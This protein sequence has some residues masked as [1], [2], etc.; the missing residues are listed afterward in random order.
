MR[1]KVTSGMVALALLAAACASGPSRRTA[2]MSGFRAGSVGAGADPTVRPARLFPETV[3]ERTSYG[4]EAGGGTRLIVS[5]LRIVS[6]SKGAIVAAE[7]RLPGPPQITMPLPERLGGGFLFV[8]GTTLWRTDRWLGPAKPIFTSPQAVHAV[9]PGLDRVYLLHGP[10]AVIALDGRSGQVLDLGPWPSSP[11]VADYAAADGWRAAA[12]A[13]MRGVVATFDA[14]AT[15]RTLSLPMQASQVVAS[16]DS[17][18][19]GGLDAARAD[20]WYELRADGSV[21]RLGS[22]PREAKATI[23]GALVPKGAPPPPVRPKVVTP[24]PPPPAPTEDKD[25]LAAKTFGKRPLA[26]AIEDGWPLTDGTAVVARDGSLARIRLVDGALTEL[27]RD[28]FPLKSARCHP[29]SLARKSNAG[30][31][32]FVCGEPRGATVL[33]AYEPVRGQL[34]ELKRFDKPRVVVS[35]GNGALTVRGPCAEDGDPPPPPRPDVLKLEKEKPGE[36]AKDEPLSKSVE[37][38]ARAP[39]P[40]LHPYCVYGHDDAWREIHVR[41]DIGGERVVVLSDGRI[42]VISPPQGAGAPARLTILDANRRATTVPITFPRVTSDVGRVLRLGLWLD[43]FEER[44]AGVLGGWIEAGGT[45]LGIEL[46]LDGKATL[47]AFLRDAGMPFVSGRY[48]LG[49]TASRL[50]YETTDGGMTWTNIEVPEPLVPAAKVDRRACGPVGCLAQGWLRVGWGEAKNATPQAAPP[51]YRVASSSSSTQLQLA[52][53]PLATMPPHATVARPTPTTPTTIAGGRIQLG[54]TSFASPPV[55]GGFNGLSELPPFFSHAAPALRDSER[56]INVDV[57][58]LLGELREDGRFERLSSGGSIARVYGWGPRT[59]DWDTLGRW[60]VK[61]QSPFFGWPDIRSSLQARPPPLV[62]DATRPAA[63]GSQA[64]LASSNFQLVPGDDASHALLVARRPSRS[65]VLLYELDSDR[66]PVEIRRAD[67]EPWNEIEGS[68]RAAGLWFVATPSPASSST[69]ATL[70]WQV[71]GGVARELVRVPRTLNTATPSRRGRLAR[72]SD[73]R[74]IALVSDGRQTL[75]RAAATRWALPIDLETGA[76]GEPESLGYVDLAERTVD[77]CS[78][79]LVGWV[80]DTTTQGVSIRLR[81]PH[82]GGALSSPL[83]R[84]RQTSSRVCI[85][86]LAGSFDGAHDG[87]SPLATG[88]ASAS[89]TR[90]TA[91]SRPG[92]L[93]VAASSNGTRF[94][95]R[96]SVIGPTA[97]R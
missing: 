93:Y 68:V 80:F 30:A 52:C 44:R 7:D 75:E 48:G 46:A 76:L 15:W 88:P 18:A 97:G 27:V 90:G 89:R 29:V 35:S 86:R 40:E 65:D 19:I 5:G 13:D 53:E 74:A 95:L 55:L 42:A 69:L 16:G 31:F 8:I 39:A 66:A 34:V 84:I 70:I 60:Q 43:G 67:G 64:S 59:G 28:A 78:D 92:E 33:Y 45:M 6:S 49:W 73:G 72:R 87:T 56:G 77:A 26:A 58:D 12:V 37:E 4:T 25:D 32:G 47:G 11:F 21:T 2:E 1:A 14:G 63:F 83:A 62:V 71:E 24:P 79:D 94:P 3:D 81:L 51:P 10:G 50:G 23:T 54:S 20:T 91:S 57:R 61:W 17:I 38:P 41:G 9:M 85:E 36:K 22:P 82:G 96:C